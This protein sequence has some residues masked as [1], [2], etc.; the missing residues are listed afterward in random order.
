MILRDV[1]FPAVFINGF[2]DV[3]NLRRFGGKMIDP[4]PSDARASIMKNQSG[5]SF[6]SK[7]KQECLLFNNKSVSITKPT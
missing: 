6:E 5:A 1:S 4:P 2:I 3:S 7:N